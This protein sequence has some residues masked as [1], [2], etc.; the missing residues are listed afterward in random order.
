MVHSKKQPKL[1]QVLKLV[2]QLSTEELIELRLQL[3]TRV[4]NLTWSNVDLRNPTQRRAFFKQEEAKAAKR[5]RRA[6]EQLQSLGII[7]E[8]GDLAKHGLPADMQPGSECDVG[9]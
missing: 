7:D 2:D 1:A 6:F 4:P 9:G 5:I 3:D 8:D